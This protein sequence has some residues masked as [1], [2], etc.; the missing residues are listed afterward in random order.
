MVM[1]SRNE[2]RARQRKITPDQRRELLAEYIASPDDQPLTELHAATRLQKSRAWLQWKRVAGG[3]PQF[4]RTDTG[5]IFYIRRDVEAYLSSSLTAHNSTSEYQAAPVLATNTTNDEVPVVPA[6][7]GK[8]IRA[9]QKRNRTL[10]WDE[11]LG[12]IA[13]ADHEAA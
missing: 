4:C 10:T 9:Q 8:R 6:A 12:E 1:K 11:A 2:R 7:L 5:K 3:G 13:K